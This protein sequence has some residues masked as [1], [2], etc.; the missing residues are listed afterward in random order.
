MVYVF[1][2]FACIGFCKLHACQL[3]GEL[4]DLSDLLK[5]ELQL[6]VCCYIM[7]RIRS[8][9]LERTASMPNH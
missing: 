2:Y 5:L 9:L 1:A 8:R 4:K 6:V 7:L 3:H